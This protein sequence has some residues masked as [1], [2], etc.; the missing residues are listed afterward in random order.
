MEKMRRI[1]VCGPPHSGKSVFLAN[2]MRQ[3]PPDSFFLAFAAPDGE[4]HWSNFGDQDLVA[5]VRQKGKFTE[6][7]VSSIVDAIKNNQQPLVLVD[8]GGV[9]SPENGRIFSVCDGCVILANK[10]TANDAIPAWREFATRNGV[11][12]LAEII[13]DLHG[14]DKLLPKGKDGKIFG[15][16]AG[17][18][19]GHTIA[20]PV[21]EVVAS[22]LREVIRNNSELTEGELLC[23][24]NGATLVDRLGITEKNDPFLGVRPKHLQNAL[25]LTSAV[26]KLETVRIWNVRA[27]ILACVFAGRLNGN[28]ELY[29]V[30]KGYFRIPE[31]TP[32]GAGCENCG[33][34]WEALELPEFTLVK[35]RPTR[36]ITEEDLPGIYPPAVNPKKPVI[37]AHDGPPMWL[38]ATVVRAYW[39]SGAPCVAMFWPVESAR[40]Q[41]HL[42]GKKWDKV[43]PFAGPAVIVAGPEE[44]IGNIIPVSFDLLKWGSPVMGKLASEEIVVDRKN[45]HAQSHSAVLPLL[46]ETIAKIHSQAR[47]SFCEEIKFNR[48]IGETI[49][50]STTDAD[51][52]V[53]A[54]RPN[55]RGLTRFV[56]N[57]QP[58][59][60]NSIVA[61]FMTADGM[62][63]SYILTTAFIGE[64]APAE[65]WDKK[66]ADEKSFAFWTSHALI[67]S[68][69]QIIPGTETSQCPW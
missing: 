67:W 64:R 33:V 16:I 15:R 38:D 24:I 63:G 27:A 3:L 11:K 49:C 29:D 34:D 8:T 57:R 51:E 65:P 45:S 10:E 21:L 9:M 35:Y 66:W 13:S 42:R 20:S 6:D 48:T 61:C 36:F 47:E 17:L 46:P 44:S 26:A 37:I 69:E 23:N 1:I 62:G 25:R 43:F 54:Q 52:I 22:R 55:R 32:K 18:E 50:V 31:V 14:A 58:E 28:V 30:A 7:F 41:E 19:R 39:R 40:P 60:T 53:Y 2:L 4:W 12:I 5:T 68:E 59:K 56:K